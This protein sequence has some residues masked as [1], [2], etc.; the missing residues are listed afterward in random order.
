MHAGNFGDWLLG[1]E[2]TNLDS[3]V[4]SPPPRPYVELDLGEGWP[5]RRFFVPDLGLLWIVSNWVRPDPESAAALRAAVAGIE[6]FPAPAIEEVRVGERQAAAPEAY[7]AIWGRLQ[8]AD[9]PP[10]G[11]ARYRVRL[12]S[13]RP[14]PWTQSAGLLIVAPAS[15][16]LFR[17]GEWLELPEAL[18]GTVRA[19]T[20]PVAIASGSRPPEF[21]WAALA[22]GLAGAALLPAAAIL[23]RRRHTRAQPVRGL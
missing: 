10:P 7:A 23:L 2:Y 11:S 20:P 8:P 5:G 21:P 22:G 9:Y 19:D 14:T 4:S 6:P 16:L 18:A 15:G 17:D 12:I 13:S 3:I 1:P